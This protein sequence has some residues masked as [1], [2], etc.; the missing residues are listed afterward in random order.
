MIK[1]TCLIQGK[2]NLKQIE[3]LGG[4]VHLGPH[5]ESNIPM[6]VIGGK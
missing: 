5:L 2:Q 6:I 4:G 1:I 3:N